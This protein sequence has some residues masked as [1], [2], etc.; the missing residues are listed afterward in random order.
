MSLSDRLDA[1]E[2]AT[3]VERQELLQELEDIED[4]VERMKDRAARL[5]RQ[6]AALDA[7]TT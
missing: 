6:I 3:C 5:M 2:I 4:L 1:D 7:R